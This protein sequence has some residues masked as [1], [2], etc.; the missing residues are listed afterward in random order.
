MHKINWENKKERRRRWVGLEIWLGY[1]IIIHHYRCL[2]CLLYSAFTVVFTLARICKI[3]GTLFNFAEKH[4]PWQFPKILSKCCK[5]HGNYSRP[6]ARVTF[7]AT[8]TDPRYVV[9]CEHFHVAIILWYTAALVDERWENLLYYS[10]LKC[11]I[12]RYFTW[13]CYC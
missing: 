4:Q 6:H 10:S 2:W 5:Y 3:N 13:F 9:V 1:F 7:D 8:W 11:N 12:Y